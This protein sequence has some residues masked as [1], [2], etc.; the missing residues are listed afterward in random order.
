V[1]PR[2]QASPYVAA[3]AANSRV[4]HQHCK[5]CTLPAEQLGLSSIVKFSVHS[6]AIVGAE[7]MIFRRKPKPKLNPCQLCYQMET[8]RFLHQLASYMIN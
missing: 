4:K 1:F 3:A 7:S 2:K 8:F 5:I 6:Q